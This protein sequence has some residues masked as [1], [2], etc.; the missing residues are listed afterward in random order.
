MPSTNRSLVALLALASGCAGAPTAGERQARAELDAVR[1]YYRPD[2]ARP[3]LPALD[4]DAPLETWLRYAMLNDPRIEAAFHAWAGTVAR[5]T[6]ARSR[7]DPALTFEADIAGAVET[8]MPGLM[9]PLP[10]PRKLAAAAEVATAE[11]RADYHAFEAEVLRTAEATRSAYVRLHFIEDS[12]RVQREALALLADVETLARQQVG[13]GR[14]TIQDVLRAEIEREQLRTQLANLED[15]RSVLGARFRAALGHDPSDETVPLPARFEPGAPPLAAEELLALATERN[16]ELARLSA[17]VRRGQALLGLA[18]ASRLP[19]VTLG[20]EA[21]VKASPVMWR[22]MI[23]VTLPIWRDRIAAEIA[24]AESETHSAEARLSAAEIELAAELAALL[25]LHR[26]SARDEELY[27]VTLL[28]KARQ[29]L[30]AARSGYAAGRS[31]FL[32]VIDAERQLL[33]FELARVAARTQ[34]ELTLASLSLAI[35]GVAPEGAPLLDLV[36]AAP[37]P[38]P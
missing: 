31:S 7:P 23:G 3:A 32:D 8:L 5:I 25:Y 35:A 34:R 17:Q 22:P 27:G 24:A 20:L 28:P 30:A 1:A 33:A 2:E 11:A 21:D 10:A 14:G 12:L 29:S 36:P 6:V 4:P 16:P 38:R 13:A 26:E 15:S 37:E 19:D 18:R 9:L